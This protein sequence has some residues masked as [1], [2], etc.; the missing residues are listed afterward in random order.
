MNEQAQVAMDCI[1]EGCDLSEKITRDEYMNL[2]GQSGMAQKCIAVIQ[3]TLEKAGLKP[4]DLLAVEWIGSSLRVNAIRDPI[5]AFFGEKPLQATM[6]AEEAV[7]IGCC[8]VCARHS[9]TTTTRAYD[10]YEFDQKPPKPKA[11]PAPAAKPA[12]AAKDGGETK[13]D[14]ETPE[15]P[16]QEGEGSEQ[17]KMDVETP[18]DPQPKME[19]E[20]DQP[21]MDI[22]ESKKE[23][24][25]SGALTPKEVEA[26]RMDECEMG[27]NDAYVIASANAKNE[28]EAYVYY[29]SEQ[30]SG[31]WKE[32]GTRQEFQAL[33]DVC[34]QTTAWLY[35]DGDDVTKEEYEQK[36]DAIKVYSEP[37]RLRLVAKQQAEEEARQKEAAAK[38]EA[39]RL[40]QERIAAEKAAAAKAAAEKAAAEKAAAEQANPSNPVDSPPLPEEKK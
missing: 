38:A 39:I 22:E 35:G 10:L 24:F 6:N 7:S 36:M 9:P 4:A 16:K 5:Q 13:M 2:I 29:V 20:P 32:F 8:L 15:Q 28:L 19:V 3:S 33:E 17:P 30:S 18:A 40:E 27:R 31:A 34:G 12:E 11:A 26:F 25:V 21:K 1:S 14:V 37:I 23:Q